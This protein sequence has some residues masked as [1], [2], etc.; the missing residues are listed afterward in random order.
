MRS[1]LSI[2]GHSGFENKL[3]AGAT[4]RGK[5]KTRARSEVEGRGGRSEAMM[6][7]RKVGMERRRR[8]RRRS[9]KDG[10]SGK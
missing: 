6:G 9:G 8:R 3:A 5:R 7:R 4:Q 1:V 10:H 2:H